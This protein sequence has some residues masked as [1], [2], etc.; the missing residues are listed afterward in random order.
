MSHIAK[1]DNPKA[2]TTEF[3]PKVLYI[4]S[5]VDSHYL[6]SD[7]N[8]WNSQ[9]FN[10]NTNQASMK[11]SKL[12]HNDPN[13]D[14]N[15]C[16]NMNN[17][18]HKNKKSDYIL[19]RKRLGCIISTLQ[20]EAIDVLNSRLAAIDSHP[21]L[22]AL[23]KEKRQNAATTHTTLHCENKMHKDN[24]IYC[25]SSERKVSDEENKKIKLVNPLSEDKN[26]CTKSNIRR[27]SK[28]NHENKKSGYAKQ[29]QSVNACSITQ[30]QRGEPSIGFTNHDISH[31]SEITGTKTV[32]WNGLEIL[33]K[34]R[35]YLSLHLNNKNMGSVLDML[36]LPIS[37]SF[38]SSNPASYL[39]NFEINFKK[40]DDGLKNI[41]TIDRILND[42]R[43][44]AVSDREALVFSYLNKHNSVECNS[45]SLVNNTKS[46]RTTL[47]HELQKDSVRLVDLLCCNKQTGPSE[48]GGIE[49]QELTSMI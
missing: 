29:S 41:S 13:P 16:Q 31:A 40:I 3:N 43:N 6:D 37:K 49:A 22:T 26:S 4:N 20:K 1:R 36:Q 35:K 48:F 32:E 11:D 5:T 42:S 25:Y 33:L 10:F 24:P 39:Q 28:E 21:I 18:L 34:L 9:C 7:S 2:S 47:N 8:L 15:P 19:I 30:T 38:Q 44:F 14:N 17:I 45:L 46:Q 23:N 27:G 12:I